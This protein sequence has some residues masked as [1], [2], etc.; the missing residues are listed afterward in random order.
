M[1]ISRSRKDSGP[2][3]SRLPARNFSQARALPAMT[4]NSTSGGAPRMM[5]SNCAAMSDG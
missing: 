1:T 2:R 4:R 5:R 3:S